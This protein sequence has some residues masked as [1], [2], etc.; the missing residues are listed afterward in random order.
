MSVA[1]SGPHGACLHAVAGAGEGRKV[2]HD[3]ACAVACPGCA[4]GD[5]VAGGRSEHALGD[6]EF[7]NEHGIDFQADIWRSTIFGFVGG[8]WTTLDVD[9]AYIDCLD[10][11]VA[12]EQ[13]RRH[14]L[15]PGIAGAEPDAVVINQRDIGQRGSGERIALQAGDAD[16]AERADALAIDLGDDEGAAAV[17]GDPVAQGD[18]SERQN[19]DGEHHADG[20]AHPEGKLSADEGRHQ[21]ACPME[22]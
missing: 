13:A 16:D 3:G 11:E 21:N 1:R 17:T 18:A 6:A 7:L 8:V 22:M 9:E 19:D 15:D 2:E 20:E 14:P 12:G 4:A 10:F 5:I